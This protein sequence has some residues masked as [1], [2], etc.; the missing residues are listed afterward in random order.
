MIKN[1]DCIVV[2]W[3]TTKKNVSSLPLW[4][5]LEMLR[6]ALHFHMVEPRKLKDLETFGL[7]TRTKIL[8]KSKLDNRISFLLLLENI[9]TNVVA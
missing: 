6:P 8:I 2:V 3:T 9:T 7:S 5:S 1:F 4:E